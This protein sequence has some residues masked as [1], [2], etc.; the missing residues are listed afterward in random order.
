MTASW[1]N[2]RQRS[3][4]ATQHLFLST[5]IINNNNM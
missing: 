2:L 5:P 3:G 1:R 4:Q